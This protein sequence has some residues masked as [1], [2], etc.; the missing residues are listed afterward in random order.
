[1]KRHYA[2]SCSIFSLATLLVVS[3]HVVAAQSSRTLP[4]QVERETEEVIVTARK[5]EETIKD[6]PLTVQAFSGTQ[7]EALGV[8]SLEALAA[9]VP[10]I[11]F[12]NSTGLASNSDLII[13]GGGAARFVNVDP[14]TGLYYNGAYIGGGNLGGRSFAASDNFDLQRAEILKG[15]QGAIY[16]RNALGGAINL[17]SRKPDLTSTSVNVMA[18]SG[19]YE[20][21]GFQVIG[22][23]PLIMGKFAMRLGAWTKNQDKGAF[24]NPALDTY[25]DSYEQ[26]LGR[27]S[28]QWSPNDRLE[29]NL[30]FDGSRG[31]DAGQIRFQKAITPDFFRQAQDDPNRSSS[32]LKNTLFTADADLGWGKAFFSANKR[33]RKNSFINDLD[34]G[35]PQSPFNAL[36]QTQCIAGTTGAMPTPPPPNQRCSEGTFDDFEGLAY[37]GRLSGSM[38]RLN[39]IVGADYYEG[40]DVYRN[41]QTG[42]ARNSFDLRSTNDVTSHALFGGIDF[43]LLPKWTIGLEARKTTEDKTS[44]STA[45]LTEAPSIPGTVAYFNNFAVNVERTTWTTFTRFALTDSVNLYGRAGTGYRSGGLQVDGRDLDPDGTGP[46][47]IALVPDTYNPEQATSYEIGVKTAWFN[48]RFTANFAA[49]QI[50]YK[51]VL[52]NVDNGLTGAN[53][54]Q[55]VTNNGNA[56]LKGVE[57][58]FGLKTNKL[59]FG[60]RIESSLG[61][62]FND[63]E[64]TS[65]TSKGFKLLRVPEWALSSNLLYRRGMGWGIEGTLG[66]TYRV[67]EGGFSNTDNTRPLPEPKT[68]GLTFGLEREG[69]SLT[70]LVDNATDD[71][72]PYADTTLGLV[73]PRTPRTYTLRVAKKFGGAR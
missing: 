70:L 6:A 28:F 3:P 10:G 65:G 26:E 38:S 1:M 47:P 35:V 25:L 50:D 15:P 22:N 56:E 63:S 37:E 2:S 13:R 16:G 21:S 60:G 64:I 12:V 8:N 39:W 67:Q 57:I 20:S 62:T 29:F 66:M 36:L 14:A 24:Y 45:I 69:Y 19:S 53:R 55:Y 23:F 4:T 31:D 42:R 68:L 7:L 40:S 52:A 59:P 46:L 17:I 49:Y 51:D 9:L 71:A 43:T 73:A 44:T 18:S 34:G 48:R 30:Q 33:V 54:I 27:L 72:E 5:R 58:E 11:E 61:V 41:T 32:D